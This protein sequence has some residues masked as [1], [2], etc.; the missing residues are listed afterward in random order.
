MTP[1]EKKRRTTLPDNET[2]NATADL[3][4]PVDIFAFVEAKE[5]PSLYFETSYRLAPT[6]GSEKVYA[7]LREIL[8]RTEKVALACVVIR[9]RQ[10]LA[11]LIPSGTALLLHTLRSVLD[12]GL[13]SRET[14]SDDPPAPQPTGQ[15]RVMAAELGEGMAMAGDAGAPIGVDI[16]ASIALQSGHEWEEILTEDDLIGMPRRHICRRGDKNGRVPGTLHAPRRTRLRRP[17]T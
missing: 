5:I 14:T 3:T 4:H 1:H 10:Y 13:P 15:D 6:P 9:E 8:E 16:G 12:M 2:G 11:A 7:L 17:R